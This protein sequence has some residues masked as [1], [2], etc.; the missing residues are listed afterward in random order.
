M[1][2]SYYQKDIRFE[3][4]LLY[5]SCKNHCV[6]YPD[7]GYQRLEVSNGYVFV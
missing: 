5:A 7:Q 3:R 1:K 4:L 6:D 2:N